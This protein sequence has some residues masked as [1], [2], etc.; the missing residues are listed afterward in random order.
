MVRAMKKRKPHPLAAWLLQN[1]KSIYGFAIES[2]IPMRSLYNHVNPDWGGLP[3]T[4]TM[5][6]IEKITG[7]AVTFD[8][9][10]EWF[11]GRK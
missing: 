1:G 11:R 5:L 9:Q 3:Q 4:G 7:G 8:A 6:R 2:G 10:M